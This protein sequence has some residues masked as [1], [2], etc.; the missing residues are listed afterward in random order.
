MRRGFILLHRFVYVLYSA[1]PSQ[2]LEA[3]G[4]MRIPFRA[5]ETAD[6]TL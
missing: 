4:G 2:P 5:V 6:A 3:I 1:P